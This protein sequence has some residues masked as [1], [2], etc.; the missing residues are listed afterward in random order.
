M[1]KNGWI[2]REVIP[3][4]EARRRVPDQFQVQKP[5][6]A[7]PPTLLLAIQTMLRRLDIKKKESEVNVDEEKCFSPTDDVDDRVCYSPIVREEEALMRLVE[8][9][10][11]ALERNVQWYLTTQASQGD[12]SYG[13]EGATSFRWGGR[14][15]DHCLAS[16]LDDY[17]RA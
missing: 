17:P 16:G 3:G 5:Y 13:K 7:N 14:M 8:D 9:Q 15:V 2:Q 10:F 4:S 12:V 1:D 11:P 6:I